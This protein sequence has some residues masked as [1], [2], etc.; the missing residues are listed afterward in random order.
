MNSD[1]E[2]AHV[3]QRFPSQTRGGGSSGAAP[4][5]VAYLTPAT[6]TAPS[7]AAPWSPAED[8]ELLRQQV[9]ERAALG[10]VL[11]DHPSALAYLALIPES[12]RTAHL[13]VTFGAAVLAAER[14]R[15]TRTDY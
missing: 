13:L 3:P 11:G 10:L 15:E 1:H 9:L 5:R 4:A 7:L 6:Y 2:T 8:A 12:S 14:I